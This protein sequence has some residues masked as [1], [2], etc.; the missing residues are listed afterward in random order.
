M[1]HFVPKY[2]STIVITK[3][4]GMTPPTKMSGLFVG[5]VIF[6][7]IVCM[8]MYDVYFIRVT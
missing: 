5:I 8:S 4:A 2:N 6:D 1:N 3:S 7:V